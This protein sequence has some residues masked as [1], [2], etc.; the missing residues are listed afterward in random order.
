MMNVKEDANVIIAKVDCTQEQELCG[1]NE[2]T[3]YP[4]LKLFKLGET[5]SIKFKGTRDMPAITEFINL[6]LNAD[7]VN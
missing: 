1:K 6:H 7:E 3:G 5:E 2:I 4:T